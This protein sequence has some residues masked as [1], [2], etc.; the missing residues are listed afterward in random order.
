M[1]WTV[2]TT[3]FL[4]TPTMRGFFRPEI[5]FFT[6]IEARGTGREGWFWMFPG[7][8]LLALLLFYLEGRSRLRPLFHVLLLGWHLSVTGMVLYGALAAGSKAYFEGAI[9]GVRLP[10]WLLAIPF[11]FFSMMAVWWVARELQGEVPPEKAAWGRIHW[12]WLGIAAALLPVAMVFF[13]FGEGFD[14]K[15][16]VAT[17]TTVV[18]WIFLTQALAHR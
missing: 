11:A 18:Q 2:F 15:T 8:A 1:G 10:L 16:K 3:T 4:W 5:S 13:H 14:W 6:I 7:L 12:K 17:A 9:W